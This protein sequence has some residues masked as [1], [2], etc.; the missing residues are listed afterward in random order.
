[1]FEK[2]EIIFSE[3]IGVCQVTELT[4]LAARNGD[5]VMYYGLRSVFDRKKVS[6]IPVEHHQVHLRPLISYEEAE[7]LSRRAAE[8]IGDL[9]RREVEY[10]LSHGGGR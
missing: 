8:D 1:M 2:K 5:Q 10:V 3:A 4:N 7:E 6:Y 9:Q